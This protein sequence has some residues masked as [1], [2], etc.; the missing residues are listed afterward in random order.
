ML[1]SANR[2]TNLV[3]QILTFSRQQPE[4]RQAIDL[5][6]I[7]AG[8]SIELLRATIPL[9]IEIDTSVATEAHPPCSPTPT[10][11]TKS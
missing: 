5:R 11:S 7:V 6:T 2:A 1:K 3:R 10:K 9:G 4:E 8:K